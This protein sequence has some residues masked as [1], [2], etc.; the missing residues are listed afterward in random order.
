[1]VGQTVQIQGVIRQRTL[2][3]T[4]AGERQNGFFIQ[5]TA[6]TA[7]ADPNSSDGI[8]VFMGRFGDLI[9]G[10][11]PTVGDEVVIQGRVTEFFNLTQPTSARLIQSVRTGV[12]VTQETPPSEVDPP[13]DSPAAERDLHPGL[14]RDRGRGGGR[15]QLAG[16][17]SPARGRGATAAAASEFRSDPS[18]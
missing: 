8:F 1:M 12:D 3:R 2:G 18:P 6:A 4:A 13:N 10:Y 7:D 9:G 15:A 17:G 16:L 5:N 14:A 11:V